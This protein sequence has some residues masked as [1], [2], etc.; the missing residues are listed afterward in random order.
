MS[1]T[2]ENAAPAAAAA[3]PASNMPVPITADL[4]AKTLVIEGL[5][6]AMTVYQNGGFMP[7]GI[8]YDDMLDDPLAAEA[9][10]NAYKENASLC[11]E[12]VKDKNG[13]PIPA[14]QPHITTECGVSITEIER[15]IVI[16]VAKRLYMQLD[17]E[18]DPEDEG[19]KFLFFFKKKPKKKEGPGRGERRFMS[20]KSLL[21]F[22]WQLPLLE[23]YRD[24][25]SAAHIMS[26]GED[27]L[28]IR[29]AESLIAATQF[30]P[31]TIRKAK[32]IM[33]DEF[34][35][36]LQNKPAALAGIVSWGSDRY[37]T[38]KKLLGPHIWTFYTRDQHDF[39]AIASLDAPRLRALGTLLA[40]VDAE[41]LKE[42]NRLDAGKFQ[43][44]VQSMKDVFGDDLLVVMAKE[45]MAHKV[46]R[47]L[48]DGFL[49]MEVDDETFRDTA[50]VSIQA[51]HAEVL[52]QFMN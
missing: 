21:G 33:G 28:H 50:G 40:T 30:E 14:D 23:T 49:H 38:F 12:F 3:A 34:I 47:R 44:V 22:G 37:K 43:A 8:D 31:E 32:A 48:V 11:D 10:V 19:K 26:L 36:V 6:K 52:E 7:G 45:K 41:N 51:V 27:I 5:R 25:F 29:S 18:E 15:L 46:L 35:E 4:E 17:K 16:T 9:F 24:H 39:N 13:Q 1:E 42:L 2:A 20:V